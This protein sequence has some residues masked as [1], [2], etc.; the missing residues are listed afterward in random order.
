MRFRTRQV[1]GLSLV[2]SFT[3]GQAGVG[4]GV[5]ARE[6]WSEAVSNGQI[7]AAQGR[8]MERVD[9]EFCVAA[10]Q[11]AVNSLQWGDLGSDDDDNN[12]DGAASSSGVSAVCGSRSAARSYLLCVKNYCPASTRP[13]H[14]AVNATC[15]AETGGKGL[16]MWMELR[17]PGGGETWKPVDGDDRGDV[18]GRPVLVTEPYY[19]LWAAT[20][21]SGF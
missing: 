20:L 14:E 6:S 9:R 4:A 19:Y 3:G 13:Q 8:E 7:T 17:E 10:C 5:Y 11:S 21:V 2:L 16:P 1:W 15:R 18:Q 12:D